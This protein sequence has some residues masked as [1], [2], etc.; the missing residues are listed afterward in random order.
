[1]GRAARIHV[2]FDG[3]P[4]ATVLKGA[5]HELFATVILA[6]FTADTWQRLA[7]MAG[8]APK[9]SPH[10]GRFHVIQH[11]E[12]EETQAIRMTDADVVTW[13]TNPDDPTA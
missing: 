12:V 9:Q 1:M 3:R 8:P 13:L 4:Q 6:R 5:A 11:G 7:P 2:I 10:P